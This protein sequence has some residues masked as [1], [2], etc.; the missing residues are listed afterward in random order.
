VASGGHQWGGAEVGGEKVQ[1]ADRLS[2]DRV[3]APAATKRTLI[4]AI[5]A[6][7]LDRTDGLALRL[8]EEGFAVRGVSPLASRAETV[9]V[10]SN[11]PSAEG[12]SSARAAVR[13]QGAHV[14]DGCLNRRPHGSRRS[15]RGL[16][17]AGQ[18]TRAS[19]CCCV[20]TT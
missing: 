19:A 7:S 2:S 10:N 9:A 16:S 13:S 6:T 20:G 8:G 15:H 12:I 18:R 3:S 5:A 14:G 4:R 1:H 17:S 11:G